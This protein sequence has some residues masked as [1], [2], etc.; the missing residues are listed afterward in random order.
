MTSDF[1]ID[2]QIQN[3]GCY[4]AEPKEVQLAKYFH[5]DERDLDFVYQRRG[6]HNRF[7]IALQLTTARFLGSFLNDLMQTPAG[8][9]RYVA[10]QL[11]LP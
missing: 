6:R 11:G 10:A 8:V 3:Y 5:L 4:V 9:R 7:G 2:D 1:L